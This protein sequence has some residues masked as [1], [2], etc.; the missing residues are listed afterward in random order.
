MTFQLKTTE[1]KLLL[2]H[3]DLINL[4]MAAASEASIPKDRVFLFSEKYNNPIDGVKDWKDM[5]GTEEEGK[6]WQWKKLS[7]KEASSQVATVNFSSG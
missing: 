2:V 6:K 1:A 3:P 7:S 5:I 4:A